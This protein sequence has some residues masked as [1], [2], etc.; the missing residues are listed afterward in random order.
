MRS[1]NFKVFGLT[2]PGFEPIGSSLK[3]TIFGFPD[4][5]KREAGALLILPPW[6]AWCKGRSCR[7]VVAWR[8]NLFCF[9]LDDQ[10]GEVSI[11]NNWFSSFHQS[12][13]C[14]CN[15]ECQSRYQD[16]FIFD[17]I[18]LNRGFESDELAKLDV[19]NSK[20]LNQHYQ[21]AMSVH[22]IKSV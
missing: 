11:S 13:S 5:P 20:R 8:T 21:A 6:L 18:G 9:I 22:C 19:G 1:I 3:P 10:I 4:L 16:L 14:L 17:D 7:S 15:A 12:L 2:R